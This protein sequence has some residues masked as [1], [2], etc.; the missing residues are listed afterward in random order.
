MIIAIEC[1]NVGKLIHLVIGLTSMFKP[2]IPWVMV[3]R[4]V[5]DNFI[6]IEQTR[7]YIF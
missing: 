6:P 1:K 2:M 7:V 5:F 4:S 3:S